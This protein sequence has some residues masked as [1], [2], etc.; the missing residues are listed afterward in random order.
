MF[1]EVFTFRGM[2]KVYSITGINLFLYRISKVMN[3]SF[4][5]NPADES[6]EIVHESTNVLCAHTPQ[7]SKKM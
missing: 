4:V 7:D 2:T 3:E 1:I 5:V 6:F